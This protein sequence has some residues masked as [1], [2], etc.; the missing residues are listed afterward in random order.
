MGNFKIAPVDRIE[1][2]LDV[3]A[4]TDNSLNAGA[5]GFVT[6]AR[7]MCV[8]FRGLEN[9]MVK[10]DPRDATIIAPRT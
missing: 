7:N 2:H 3:D 6:N 1:G 8:M 5:G 9:V 4:T 10:R